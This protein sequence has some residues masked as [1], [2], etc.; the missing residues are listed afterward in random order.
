VAHYQPRGQRP[1]LFMSQAS[2]FAPGKPIRGGVPVIFP[3]FGPRAGDSAAPMHGFARLQPWQVE[4][5]SIEADG[6]V[7]VSL[8]LGPTDF[9]RSLW[10]E[11]FALRYIVQV[12]ASLDMSLEVRNTGGRAFTFEDALH[13]YLAVGDVRQIRVDGLAGASYIDKTDA[14]KRKVHDGAPL[15]INAETDRL[16]LNTDATVTVTDPVLGRQLEVQKRGSQSTVV[17]NPWIA[18]AKAMA[19]FGDQEWPSMV[20]IEAV[21]AADNAVQLPPGQT[22]TLRQILKAL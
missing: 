9:S 3:W 16:Y 2:S 19:D 20:C 7:R 21:N 1:V 11:D 5:T 4:S 12:G 14:M 8:A 10:P 15:Q 22:H 13:T 18:K 17:W 6:S